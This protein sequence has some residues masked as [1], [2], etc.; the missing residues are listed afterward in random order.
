MIS[1]ISKLQRLVESLKLYSRHDLSAVQIE[2][3]DRIKDLYC[4][5]KG[6]DTILRQMLAPGMTFLVGRRG[7]GKSTVFDRAQYE[8]RESGVKLGCYI[9]LKDL[10]ENARE[11]VPPVP[12]CFQKH[13]MIGADDA[14]QRLALKLSF[15][16][17][18]RRECQTR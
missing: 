10:F 1:D 8:L 3:D 4:D 16:K 14:W 12:V 5:P 13:G 17:L 15:V 6:S 11:T 9:N 7:T 2:P 18:E